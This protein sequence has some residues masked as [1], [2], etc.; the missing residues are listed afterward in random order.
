MSY[1]VPGRPDDCEFCGYA[2]ARAAMDLGDDPTTNQ[3]A[4][5]STDPDT[6]EESLIMSKD[7]IQAAAQNIAEAYPEL[8]HKP[9]TKDRK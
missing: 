7:E 4:P 5:W 3:Y 6:P 9:D 8:V 2:L 1:T